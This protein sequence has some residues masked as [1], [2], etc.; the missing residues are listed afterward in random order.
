MQMQR[1]LSCFLFFMFHIVNEV[2]KD[3]VTKGKGKM[4]MK[5]NIVLRVCMC[6]LALM[7]PLTAFAHSGRTD[8]NGGHRDNK[9]KSGLGYY[10]YHCGGYPPHLHTN[11]VCPYTGG[12]SSSATSG[13][14]STVPASST[15]KKVYASRIDAV[16][17]PKSIDAGE[18]S[19]LKGKVYPENAEDDTVTWSTQTPEIVSVSESGTLMAKAPGTA[20][21][22]AK[23]ERG[24]VTKFT[25]AVNEVQAESIRIANKPASITLKDEVQLSVEFSPENTTDKSVLW[26]SENEQVATVSDDGK[27]IAKHVG[28][29]VIT[30]AH[31]EIQDS[32]EVEIIPIKVNKIEI[33]LPENAGG[34]KEIT[35][36]ENQFVS[37]KMKKGIEVQLSADILPIDATD[38]TVM[39]SVDNNEIAQISEDGLL[40]T[41]SLGRVIVRAETKDGK[42]DQVEIE[43]YSDTAGIAGGVVL[44]G[45]GLAA[46]GLFYR[47]K[48]QK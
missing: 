48:K 16:S 28:N 2:T 31:G 36:I 39:W 6:L 8:G 30:A 24:T 20:V 47:K 4:Q 5:K 9:N 33:I 26:S 40:K 29:T 25:I 13:I 18:S 34:M 22:L 10:H 15:P 14:K 38:K 19:M 35:T 17:V 3:F 23:T 12:G 41:L 32:F 1:I 27:L 11:G 45:A 42:S 46:A 44:G 37:G 43:V 7:I 21:V